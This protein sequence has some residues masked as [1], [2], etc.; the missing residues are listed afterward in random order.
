MATH[1]VGVCLHG[2]LALAV[3]VAL[4]ALAQ[5]ADGAAVV[6]PGGTDFGACPCDVT[7]GMCDVGCCCD[8][9]CT[10]PILEYFNASGI[11]CASTPGLDPAASRLCVNRDKVRATN[12][13]D[14]SWFGDLLCV[15]TDNYPSDG[16]F[17]PPPPSPLNTGAASAL[18]AASSAPLF[19]D[20]ASPGVAAATRYPPGAPLLAAP[21]AAAGATTRVL[22]PVAAGPAA[23][24]DDSAAPAFLSASASSCVRTLDPAATS[25]TTY[26]GCAAASAARWLDYGILPSPSSSAAPAAIIPITAGTVTCYDSTDR[27][28]RA[29][30][31]C[32][33]DAAI[34]YADAG[35]CRNL[36]VSVGLT[37]AYTGDMLVSAASL[38][39]DVVVSA[40][41]ASANASF[42]Y[43]ADFAVAFVPSDGTV[44]VAKSGNPGYAAGLPVRGGFKAAAAATAITAVDL[45]LAAGDAFGACIAPS[46]GVPGSRADLAYATDALF[47]CRIELDRAELANCAALQNKLV[48]LLLPNATVNVVA[49]WGSSETDT[50]ADWTDIALPDAVPT[51]AQ[52]TG[53]C[54]NMV[55][56]V[57][58]GFVTV[59]GGAANNPQH[60]I[61]GAQMEYIVGSVTDVAPGSP[62]ALV[63]PRNP[64]LIPE[65]P[66]DV[67]YPFELGSAAPGTSPLPASLL[68][69]VAGVVA[70]AAAIY[71]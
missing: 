20:P 43:L 62:L 3:V 34:A 52:G 48:S 2:A 42:S 8:P 59:A 6:A 21:T 28:S 61:I 54:A 58:Y 63:F 65:L 33:S 26:S 36:V 56:G 68:A 29:I 13:L 17:F 9:S 69:A 15:T 10:T 4:V 38:N 64:N 50:P 5:S 37:V 40:A 19:Q 45:T 18:L 1:R 30:V 47:G 67:W 25:A 35:G 11:A 12:G 71:A 16:F 57:H 27:A 66:S 46:L 49:A 14:A 32:P 70:I 31:A 44:P 39:F 23:A 55:V 24:C 41:G 53:T 7:G 22:G 51:P 60:K